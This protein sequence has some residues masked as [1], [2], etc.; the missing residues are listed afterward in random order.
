MMSI[1]NQFACQAF[2]FVLASLLK[3]AHISR[4]GPES[5]Y[6]EGVDCSPDFLQLA[7]QNMV[8]ACPKLLQDNVG[9]ICALYLDGLKEARRR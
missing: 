2:F 9:T 3:P 1:W 5:C 4:D 7:K 6:Y 8:C